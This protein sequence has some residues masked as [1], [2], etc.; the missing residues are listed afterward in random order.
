MHIATRYIPRKDWVKIA[1]EIKAVYR[2]VS[3]DEAKVL[4]EEFK[5]SWAKHGA[6]VAVWE[7]LVIDRE[8][9]YLPRKH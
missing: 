1:K 9:L 3:L 4:F 7:K 6:A 5:T 8:P 2:A